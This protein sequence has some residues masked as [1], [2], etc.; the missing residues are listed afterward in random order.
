M[1]ALAAAKSFAGSPADGSFDFRMRF[2]VALEELMVIKSRGSELLFS[3]FT[4]CRARVGYL[5][6]N[7][8]ER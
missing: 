6:F 4:I 7:C 2:G 5:L 1:S 3:L 8:F